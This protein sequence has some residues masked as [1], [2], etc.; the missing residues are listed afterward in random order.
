MT[1]RLIYHR[2]KA[3]T[4][5]DTVFCPGCGHALIAK[6]VAEALDEMNL[7][8]EA[9]FIGGVGCHGMCGGVLDVDWIS[10]LHGRAPAVA[11]GIKRGLGGKGLVV[12]L[13]GDGD[14][15]AIG[16]GDI[17]SAV[18]RG[19]KLTTIFFN[20]AGYGTTGG[21]M[22]P[23]S[24]IG[25]ITTTTPN[26]RDPDQTGYPVHMAELMA[27]M[28]GVAFSARCALTNLKN[29]LQGKKAVKMAFQKQLDG[30]GYGFVEFLS[31]CPPGWNKSPAQSLKW[32][33]AAMM[34]EYSL[35]E[36]KNIQKMS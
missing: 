7:Q 27:S 13:Q 17:L 15:A 8:G 30:I 23:T 26:G 34:E 5:L 24:L 12:T 4:G 22:A 33:E 6:V 10:S 14:L 21:Q 28:R 25:Q 11:T 36:F 18:N 19:E 35:G 29:Y 16:L 1:E 20:N 2:P 3:V 9:I 32:L 31:T